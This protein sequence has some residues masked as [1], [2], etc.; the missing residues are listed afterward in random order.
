MSKQVGYYRFPSIH[1]DTIVF[2]CEDDLW[3]VP[4][5]GGIPTRLTANLGEVSHPVL[6]PD[7][8]HLAFVGREEGHMEVYW[9][10]ATGGIAQRLTFLG[11]RTAVVGWSSDSQS[12]RFRSVAGQPF[13]DISNIYQIDRAGGLPQPLPVGLAHQISSGSN[14]GIVIG[15]N[16]FRESAYWKRYRG[17]TAGVIWV[18]QSGDGNFQPLIN[19]NG[20][21]SCPM[22]IGDRIFFVSDF[23][24]IGNL[25]SCTPTGLELTKHT[26]HTE[27]Y[28]RHAATDS[29]RIVYQAGGDLFLY[30]PAAELANRQIDIEFH[31]PQVQRQRKFVDTAKFME[32]YDLHPDGHSVMVTTRGK[33]FA[34]GNWEGAVTQLGEPDGVR[35]RLTRWLNDS[36]TVRLDRTPFVT[37]SDRDGTEAIEL[38]STH[39]QTSCERLANLDIGRAIDLEVSPVANKVVLS[40]HRHEVVLIDLDTQQSRILDRSE[41]R[42]IEGC[43][44]SPDGRWVAYSCAETQQTLSIKICNIDDGRVYCLTPP[45]FRDFRPAFDP[46]GKFIYFLSV[47]EFNPVYDTIFFD[48]N[49]P[50]G[51]RPYLISLTA[52]TPSPFIPTPRPFEDGSAHSKQAEASAN[53]R[54]IPNVIV[55]F[56]GIDRRIVAFPIPEGIYT[57]IWGLKGKVI[58]SSLPVQ[59]SLDINWAATE[60]EAEATLEVFDFA[61]QKHDKVAT[62]VTDFR[63]ARLNETLIYRSKNRLRVCKIEPLAEGTQPIKDEPSRESGWLDLNRIKVSVIPSQEWQQ[64]LRE[65][66]QLQQDHFWTEDMSGVDWQRVFDR[67]APLLERVSTRSEFSDLV[68]EMQGEL[69]TSHAYELGG[70][71]RKEPDY[72]LGFL[73]ADFAYDRA[74][75]AYRVEHIVVGDPWDEKASSPLQRLGNNIQVGALLLAVGGQRVSRQRSP[76]ELLVH[77]SG[78]EVNLTFAS[79]ESGSSRTIAVK[80]LASETP[81]RYRDWVEMN[82][83][84]VSE[85]TGG[86]VGYLHIPDM[87]P[88]GYAEF[89]R[90]Y[91]VEVEKDALI[92]DVRYNGGGHVSALLL[93]KLLRKRI[94]YDVPRWGKPEPYPA[95]SVMGPIVALTNEYAGSDGDIFSHCFKLMNLGTLIGKRTWGG[96]IGIWPRHNLVDGSLTSQPEF[97]FW[98]NDVGWGVENYGTDPDIQV[99]I[100][101][102]DWVQG[103]DPQIEKGIQV[104]LEQLAQNAIG[105]PEFGDRPQLQLPM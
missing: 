4:V 88:H 69:G 100:S 92:V 81:A 47:R 27:Y 23:E 22:W 15:R 61:T 46:A 1:N 29:E 38:W 50:R 21:L 80:T 57:Q 53:S 102:S 54:D 8:Q 18:D 58:F 79:S 93:E 82:R 101:P 3:R 36:D 105:L 42:R 19:L 95:E 87:S 12:I 31:S 90:Y 103:K 76:Q 67:Y 68:W 71:Y 24:G 78:C 84:K 99:E 44:W 41:Y 26:N 56:D 45:R 32:D 7:G 28:V 37:I 98:F 10:P 85:A 2:V 83:A 63:V 39:L 104:I 77:Q 74:T 75:D 14:G 96:V 52:D 64:M 66:W 25:Y 40:N 48:L 20:D 59:G 34:L 51:I 60:P 62:E 17:G 89:H 13:R 72:K 65:I 33:S 86:K 35:Y 91:A 94:G 11:T 30:D 49:F 55:D 70:D 16:N 6:S 73:G 5:S 43:C 9:M 97:S